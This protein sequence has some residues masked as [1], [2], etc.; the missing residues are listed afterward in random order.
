MGVRTLIGLAVVAFL[1]TA[2]LGYRM[3]PSDPPREEP[4]IAREG[5]LQRPGP[6]GK[7]FTPRE[8]EDG[9]DDGLAERFGVDAFHR[10]D[11]FESD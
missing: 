8:L 11:H 1:V 9:T 2:F 4:S 10:S 3:R 6:T 7:D 5:R